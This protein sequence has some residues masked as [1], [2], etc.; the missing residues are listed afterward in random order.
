VLNVH[1]SSFVFFSFQMK[2]ARPDAKQRKFATKSP[3]DVFV[4]QLIAHQRGA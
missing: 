1:G 4:T 2:Y 3:E